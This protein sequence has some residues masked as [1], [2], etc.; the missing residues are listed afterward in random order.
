MANKL[1][2]KYGKEVGKAAV[3][4]TDEIIESATKTIEESRKLTDPIIKGRN[5][6]IDEGKGY[7]LPSVR[8]GKKR[9]N[10]DLKPTQGLDRAKRTSRIA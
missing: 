4:T 2:N 5:D 3:R 7:L 1:V 8:K 6:M 10:T 9:V